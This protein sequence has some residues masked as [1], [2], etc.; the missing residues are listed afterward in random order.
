MG[1]DIF[2]VDAE[3]AEQIPFTVRLGLAYRMIE[4][5]VHDLNLVIDAYREFVNNDGNDPDP[6]FVALGSDFQN[7][8]GDVNWQS[9]EDALIETQAS[10]GL[11]Y[12]YVQFLALRLGFLFDWIGERYE[13][14]F[15]LGLRYGGINFDWSYIHSPEGMMK[16]FLQNINSEKEGATGAR[17]GQ[18]RLSLIARF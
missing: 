17:H 15:G 14:T 13:L 4:T 8:D 12:W 9:I 5:P 16:D 3:D 2:Y 1:P 11:E 7:E 10:V 6:F 18:W